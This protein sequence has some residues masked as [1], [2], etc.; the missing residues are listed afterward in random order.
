MKVSIIIPAYNVEKYIERTLKSCVDQSY[1][2]VEI[3]VINDGSTDKTE[4]IINHCNDRRVKK[5]SQINKGVS[6]ARNFGLETATGNF[7]IFVDGDDWLEKDAV[8]KL[9]EIYKREKSFVISTYKDAYLE[10]EDIC[11]DASMTVLGPEGRIEWKGYGSSYK[12]YFNLKSSCYKLYDMQIIHEN[13]IVFNPAI[14]NGEDGLFVCQY[15]QYVESIYYLPEQLW[16][17]L[18]RADSAT[19]SSF[20]PTQLS[21][22]RAIEKMDSY[23]KS[24]DDSVFFNQYRAERI[25]YYAWQLI[26]SKYDNSK[27]IKEM[28]GYI[29][30]S[31]STYFAG[32]Y[33]V[34]SKL[35]YL[36]MIFW[37]LVH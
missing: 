3:I 11:I 7:C 19:R 28:R 18:N 13:G 29:V 16:V 22:L 12:P 30:E 26:L 10:N 32:S 20:K 27:I 8:R 15:L 25:Y 31:A 17:I 9:V 33:K 37:Y 4:E 34:Q 1:E 21:I 35:K 6:A 36:Y 5:L 24:K 14:Q 23:S 2:D